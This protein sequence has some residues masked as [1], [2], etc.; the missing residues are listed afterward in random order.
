MAGDHEGSGEIAHLLE[1]LRLGAE[2]PPPLGLEAIGAR[3]PLD[4]LGGDHR[5][6]RRRRRRR[7]ALLGRLAVNERGRGRRQR[8]E[9]EGQGGCD[10]SAVN[11]RGGDEEIGGDVNQW[12]SRE[13]RPSL[14]TLRPTA[15]SAV[16]S[17]RRR[18]RVPA[19]RPSGATQR[20]RRR[21]RESGR[22]RR[23]H[24]RRH[25]R[26]L[27]RLRRFRRRRSSSERAARRPRRDKARSRRSGCRRGGV[28]RRCRRRQRAGARR[29]R[30]RRGIVGD[31]V[32]SSE[33]VV[34]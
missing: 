33:S 20:A 26:R 25:R 24:R 34:A 22:S 10:G 18:R 32:S 8:C 15:R 23:R 5:A 28:V 1:E 12:R 13:M 30:Y 9:G 27:R 21:R 14:R 31:R 3:A 6:R 7:D 11:A 2:L 4:A 17:A 29:R 19:H 16:P